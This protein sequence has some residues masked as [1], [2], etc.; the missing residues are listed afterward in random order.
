MGMSAR[1]RSGRVGRR[2]GLDRTQPVSSKSLSR[3]SRSMASGW[4]SRT[5]R[6]RRSASEM[7]TYIP[8]MK[9]LWMAENVIASLHNIYTLRGAPVRDPSELVEVHQSGAPP[10]RRGSRGHV[11]LPPLADAGATTR[12]QEMLRCPARP[13]RPHEQPGAPSR[14]PGRDDQS[15]LTTS[16]R[17]R[18]SL[19]RKVVLPRLS[20]LVPST[21]S[22][23]S[24]SA[25]L[26]SGTA[27]RPP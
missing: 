25:T 10:V 12:V 11:C 14:Q 8:A 2:D 4:S 21:T 9:R 27:T 17:C 23:A 24:S 26:A 19:Q 7:N 18:Q 6:V 15:G 20:R 1:A 22:V 13:L 5:R 3:N 16:T